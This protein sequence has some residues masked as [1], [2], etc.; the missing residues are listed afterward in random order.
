M[1]RLQNPWPDGYSINTN[2]PY[3]WRIHPISKTRKFHHGVDVGGSFQV[4]VPADGKVQKI[5]W[6]ADG[7]GHTVLIDHGDIVTVYYHGA[8][9]TELHVGQKVRAGDFIYKSGNTGAS[10]GAHLHFE[11]RKPG[12]KWGDTLDPELFLP[13]E[14]GTPVE[15]LQEPI[16]EP[17][18][19]PVV[20]SKAEPLKPSEATV[21]PSLLNRVS[22]GLAAWHSSWMK[23][24]KR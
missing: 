18:P 1:S 24:G 22:P 20:E 17:K 2:S 6:S 19:E 15:K 4:T 11:V 8:H 3:G 14:G 13:G 23:R 16:S 9:R 10:T 7:G 5:G 21:R 12:G